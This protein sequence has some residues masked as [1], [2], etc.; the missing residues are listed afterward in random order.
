MLQ[1]REQVLNAL[2]KLLEE[3]GGWALRFTPTEIWLDDEP[4]VT[5]SGRPTAEPQDLGSSGEEHLA[6]AFYQDGIRALTFP[7]HAPRE[8]L[9]ALFDALRVVGGGPVTHDDLVTL[10]WQANLTHIKVD[11]APLEQQIYLSADPQAPKSQ[12]GVRPVYASTPG[13][14]EFHAELGQAAGAQGLH[15]DTFDDWELPETS[16]SVPETYEQLSQEMEFSRSHFTHAWKEEAERDWKQQAVEVLREI[17]SLDPGE[18]TRRSLSH[19]VVTWVSAALQ[20][21]SLHEAQRAVE[22]LRELDPELKFSEEELTELMRRIN[23]KPLVEYLDEADSNEQ[24]R[25]AAFAVGLGRPGIDL[26]F[27]VMSQG[28]RSR[29]RAAASTALCYQCAGNPEMLEPY[30]GSKDAEAVIHIVF[31][32]GQIGG[33]EV[34]GLLHVAAQHPDSRV[35]RQVVQSLG[36]VPAHDRLPLL[37]EQLDTED[38][39]LLATTLNMVARERSPDVAHALLR[40]IE[41]PDFESR[42]ED[43]QRAFFQALAEVAGDEVVPTLESLLHRGGWFAR[44]SFSRAA[45]ARTLQ[46]IGTPAAQAVLTGGLKSRAAAVRSACQEAL[47]VKVTP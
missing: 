46:R 20:R 28:T 43:I 5:P 33:P 34:V 7:P 29:T 24:G 9:E 45:A 17:I 8:E 6:F 47:Q 36:S 2:V 22:L 37:L 12:G 11:S 3:N 15:R 27:S 1:A 32:L 25:F 16:A 42:G 30:L 14:D 41:G 23:Y 10:L 26:A 40:W 38:P 13:G 31:V 4:V 21:S 18:D 35:R 19:S 39:Q 44:R